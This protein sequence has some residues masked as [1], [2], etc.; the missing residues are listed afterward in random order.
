MLSIA[1]KVFNI[2]VFKQ[3]KNYILIRACHILMINV[4]YYF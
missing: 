2:L 1:S 3:E 4:T